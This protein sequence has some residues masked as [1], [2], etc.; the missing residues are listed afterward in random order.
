V[1]AAAKKKPTPTLSQVARESFAA[2]GGDT[3][4]ATESLAT[5]LLDD[6]ALLRAV[7]WPAVTKR[8][9]A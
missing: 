2:A 7:Q 3:A 8:K 9:L 1:S 5:R 6:R 4:L